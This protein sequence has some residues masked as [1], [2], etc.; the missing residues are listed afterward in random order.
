M[1][2][3]PGLVLRSGTVELFA[4]TAFTAAIL[5]GMGLR[6]GQGPDSLATQ[7]YAGPGPMSTPGAFSPLLDGL[8]GDVP[9]L[10]RAV[11][12]VIT[13]DVVF[14]EFYGFRLPEG[15]LKEIHL[16]RVERMLERIKVLRDDPLLVARSPDQRVLGRCRHYTL[17]LVTLLRTKGIPARARVGFG[18]YFDP[19]SFEDHWVCEYWD[20]NHHR[21]TLVDPQMDELWK[22][23]LHL[24]IDAMDVPRDQFVVAAQAWELCR[25]GKVNPSKFG[26]SFAD[27]HGMWFVANNLLRD[28]ASLNKMEM[29]PWDSW[30]GHV[31]PDEQ[32]SGSRLAFLDRIASLTRHPDNSFEELRSAYDTDERCRVPSTVFNGILDRLEEV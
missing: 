7:Y 17:L 22:E 19:G 2:I 28:L 5:M 9:S 11:Q 29:L 6:K 3:V 15:R 14:P 12:G 26:I 23:R 4:V 13:Y 20:E 1:E 32:V 10:V 21:W 24:R 25:S 18:R 27:L 8:P 16:R 31:R 30:G